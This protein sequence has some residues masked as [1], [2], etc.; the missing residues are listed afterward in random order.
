[1][2]SIKRLLFMMLAVLFLLATV[3]SCSKN[4]SGSGS[5]NNQT[6]ASPSDGGAAAATTE[7]YIYPQM[8][9]A[10]A[11]FRILAPTT[12]WF[13]YTAI[14]HDAMTGDVLD[15]AIYTRNRFIESKFNIN[16]KEISMDI[17]KINAQ[18]QKTTLAG[19][20]EYDAAFCPANS[21]GNIGALITQNSFCNLR[22]ISTLNLD[23]NWWN[24]TMAKEAAIGAGNKLYYAGCGIDIMTLQCVSCVFFNQDMMTNLGLE[25]PYNTA[26]NGKWTFDAFNGG[27]I[28]AF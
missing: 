5:N 12:T 23:K 15:D 4:N 1:M 7:E 14:T 13:F 9:G 16:I 11:D 21:S 19:S 17:A 26:R 18:L 2:K 6:D 28:F 8:D 27:F 22:D 10:G 3:I 24:Q 25:L 20:D